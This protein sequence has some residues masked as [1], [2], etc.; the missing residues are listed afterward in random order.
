LFVNPLSPRERV[1]E[2]ISNQRIILLDL[3]P[4]FLAFSRR[5]KEFSC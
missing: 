5:E 3:H 2:R 4:L 1:G